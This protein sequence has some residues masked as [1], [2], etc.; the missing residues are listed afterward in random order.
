MTIPSCPPVQAHASLRRYR[1]D[2]RAHSHGFAQVLVGLAGRL[3]LEVDGRA[4]VVD[5][6]SGLV[7][8]AGAQHAFMAAQEASVWVVDAPVQPGLDRWRRFAAPHAW[9]R[10]VGVGR[11]GD[12]MAAKALI[13]ALRQAPQVQVRRAVELALLE[14][15]LAASLHGTWPTA[16]MAAL[17]GLSPQRF[18]ARLLAL[19]GETPQGLLRRLRLDR[20]TDLLRAG[21]GLDTVALQVGYRTASALAFALRRDRGAGARGLRRC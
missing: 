3:E 2:Y 15:A 10:S 13:D 14:P 7:I 17:F 4:A 6:S 19:T 12:A 21:H 5:A 16:R 20:A 9:Q 8:P 11:A 1:G 18:H